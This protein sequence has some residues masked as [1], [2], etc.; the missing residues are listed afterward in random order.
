MNGEEFFNA[1]NMIDDDLIEEA[2]VIKKRKKNRKMLFAALAACL[3]VFVYVSIVVIGS[4]GVDCVFNQLLNNRR[5]AI[6]NFARRYLRCHIGW[7]YSY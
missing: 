1:I 5:R 3:A 2:A 4:L 7:Q 6:Y